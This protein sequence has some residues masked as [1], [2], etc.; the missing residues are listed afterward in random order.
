MTDDEI[1]EKCRAE[2]I[3]RETMD[4]PEAESAVRR[5]NRVAARG[6]RAKN[7]TQSTVEGAEITDAANTT[8]E[9]KSPCD[10][11]ASRPWAI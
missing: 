9:A 1:L 11:P 4:G 2:V 3:K 8:P 10:S 7:S 6:Q 5:I